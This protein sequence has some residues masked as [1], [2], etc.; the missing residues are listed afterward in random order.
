MSCLEQ[1]T[2]RRMAQASNEEGANRPRAAAT[3]AR[4]QAGNNK[5]LS[6]SALWFKRLFPTPRHIKLAAES[7]RRVVDSPVLTRL[8]IRS[9]RTIRL[10]NKLSGSVG[11]VAESTQDGEADKGDHLFGGRFFAITVICRL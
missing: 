6:H 7:Y 5:I 2:E 1:V 11:R 8:A 3:Q 10:E 9:R 4:G